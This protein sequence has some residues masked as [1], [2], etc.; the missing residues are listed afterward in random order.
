MNIVSCV[1]THSGNVHIVTKDDIGKAIPN[2]DGL[3]T[4]IKNIKLQIKTADC[5]PLSLRDNSKNV[6]GL[7][8]AGWRGTKKEIIKKAIN[9]FIR[10]FNSNPNDI[11]I[12]I[13][14]A[15][16]KDNYIVRAD[17]ANKF[18]G[19]YPEFLEK[20]SEDQWKFDLIGVSIKQ[21]LDMGIPKK[22]IYPS[23]I[24]TYLN[25]NYP[26]YRRDGN[27]NGFI[28]SIMFS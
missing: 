19:D 7:V 28:T 15:I 27:K 25:K 4:N 11:K 10:K 1:Q 3:I 24:S 20:V 21:I 18:L 17:V 2:C 6:I 13:G 16:D 9:V 12:K 8:H 23:N 22:N 26:S 14:P 5:L